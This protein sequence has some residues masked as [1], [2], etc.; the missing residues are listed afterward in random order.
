MATTVLPRGFS[1]FNFYAFLSDMVSYFGAVSLLSPVTI[2]PLYASR[3]T[4]DPTVIAL[5]PM[6]N[7]LGVTLPQILGARWVA[8]RTR[9]RPFVVGWA[10]FERICVLLAVI[11]ISAL[12][13]SSATLRL[14]VPIGFL[15]LW[16]GA[17]GIN[18]PAY[19]A[20]LGH[21]IPPERRGILFGIGAAVGGGAGFLFAGLAGYLLTALP[22]PHG[23]AACGAIAFVL[24][25][26]G[27]SPLAFV[28]ETPGPPP[29]T[30]DARTERPM[31]ILRA[32]APFRIYLLSQVLYGFQ[33][34]PTAVWTSYALKRFHAA[35]A[36][37]VTITAVLAISGGVAVLIAGWLA[38]RYGNRAVLL[39]STLLGAVA[40]VAGW[41]APTLP[42]YIATFVPT[43]AALA[44]WQLT[45]FNILME[46][47]PYG[48]VP[49]YSAV[50]AI[51]VGPFRVA[52]P[53]AGG[54]MAAALGQ[55]GPVFL[56]SAVASLAAA[57]VLLYV[58][59][60]RWNVAGPFAVEV[61]G[62][63][64]ATRGEE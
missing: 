9:Y 4:D 61:D 6:L 12:A 27:F 22:F 19:T 52:A 28:R 51:V 46:F 15:F 5:I 31:G 50:S 7:S 57:I 45:S 44:G 58:P 14:W 17:M 2:L 16:W 36:D 54:L 29:E 3:L 38:D 55:S 49:A 37:I 23:F 11:S 53:L 8:R 48:R 63:S 18:S 60:P 25:V 39:G 41:G 32:D 62:N 24:L 20:M 43:A 34:M 35:D 33:A 10:A 13:G 30:L 42:L 40:A 47:A 21:A 56:A 26:A 59:E 1:R 64:S